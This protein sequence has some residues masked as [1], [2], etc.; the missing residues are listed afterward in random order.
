MWTFL[1]G[2]LGRMRESLRVVFVLCDVEGMRRSEIAALLKLPGGTVASRL[3]LARKQ[4][5]T[6]I[7]GQFESVRH[8]LDD[9]D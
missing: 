1:A 2:I 7:A 3:R 6:R 8:R 9:D 5:R 4:V